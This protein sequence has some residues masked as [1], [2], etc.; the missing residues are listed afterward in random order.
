MAGAIMRCAPIGNC[1]VST[2]EWQRYWRAA[3]GSTSHDG[4]TGGSRL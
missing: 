2:N 1:K 4:L 3:F